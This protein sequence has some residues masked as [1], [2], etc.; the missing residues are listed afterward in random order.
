MIPK[1]PDAIIRLIVI[2]SN[3]DDLVKRRLCAFLLALVICLPAMFAVATPSKAVIVLGKGNAGNS[4]YW[5]VY[6]NGTLYIYGYGKMKDYTSMSYPVWNAYGIKKVVISKGV[7]SI[8]SYAFFNCRDMTAISI[9]SSVTTIGSG[10]FL[11][12][13]KLAEVHVESID[14]WCKLT[15]AMD[16]YGYYIN[17]LKANSNN[18]QL[19]VDTE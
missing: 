14:A 1:L 5:E 4:V 15:N 18:K 10:A 17:P 3:G 16:S 8:G 6:D 13:P 12:C 2:E 19:Y 9:P 7:T 11:E